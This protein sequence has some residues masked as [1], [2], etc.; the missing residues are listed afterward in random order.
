MAFALRRLFERARSRIGSSIVVL[1]DAASTRRAIAS[2]T[3][4]AQ[5]SASLASLIVSAPWYVTTLV[6]A[7]VLYA[8]KSAIGSVALARRRRKDRRRN[9]PRRRRSGVGGNLDDDDK[10]VA[11]GVPAT[12]RPP[13]ASKGGGRYGLIDG[14]DDDDQGSAGYD[15]DDDYASDPDDSATTLASHARE[16]EE[17][18]PFPPNPKSI[19]GLLFRQPSVV[20]RG[21]AQHHHHQQQ[22]QQMSTWPSQQFS[23]SSSSLHV[24]RLEASPEFKTFL[25]SRGLTA[26]HAAAA[27]RRLGAYR[28]LRAADPPSFRTLLLS[29]AASSSRQGNTIEKGVEAVPLS[30]PELLVDSAA[31]AGCGALALLWWYSVF[32]SWFSS[33]SSSPFSSFNGG[34][35]ALLAASTALSLAG[36]A[37]AALLGRPFALS[38][39]FSSKKY[40]WE[41][42]RGER[43]ATPSRGRKA[44][45]AFS[46]DAAAFGAGTLGLGCVA[47]ALARCLS[48][49]RE[50][51][52]LAERVAGVRL[53]KERRYTALA[54]SAE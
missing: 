43:A 32:V 1:L 38:L 17:K 8:A 53:V 25:K 22:Q 41:D 5:F 34:I 13:T 28:E 10:D 49:G 11:D 23:S 33:P 30:V 31:G 46:L 48:A 54:A 3:F 26:E 35:P 15:D 42:S 39:L 19:S 21:G 6:L 7:A 29:S 52:S 4:P 27:R 9:A 37:S 14:H 51:S 20:S 44:A 47:G 24:A 36:L 45:L 16:D 18:Q 2:A 40:W 50:R 12:T